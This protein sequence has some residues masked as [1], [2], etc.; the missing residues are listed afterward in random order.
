MNRFK[1]PV[2][3]SSILKWVKEKLKLLG[4]TKFIKRMKKLPKVAVFAVFLI[5][6]LIVANSFF[7][8]IEQPMEVLNLAKMPLNSLSM[9]GKSIWMNR[10]WMRKK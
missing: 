8:G 3:F 9:S 5:T 6:L 1:W 10:C 2:K 7:G 4:S